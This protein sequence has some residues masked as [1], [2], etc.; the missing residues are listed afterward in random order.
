MVGLSEPELFER[1]KNYKLKT[2]DHKAS[3]ALLSALPLYV[4]LSPYMIPLGS[5]NEIT[6]NV[7]SEGEEIHILTVTTIL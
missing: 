4:H 1:L 6:L 2:Y 7:S 3:A 5:D